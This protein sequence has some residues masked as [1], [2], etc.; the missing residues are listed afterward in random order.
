MVCWALAGEPATPDS[1][2]VTPLGPSLTPSMSIQEQAAA[3]K[4]VSI[5]WRTF[6]ESRTPPAA[7]EAVAEPVAGALA[8]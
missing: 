8:G 7:V 3:G 1:L 5:A 6:S 2:T 4:A